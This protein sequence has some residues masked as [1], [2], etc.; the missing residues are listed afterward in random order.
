LLVRKEMG[1]NWW[2]SMC[3]IF[4]LQIFKYKLEFLELWIP[5][6]FEVLILEIFGRNFWKLLKIKVVDWR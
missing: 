1:E 3:F 5:I 2:M 6:V 4:Y